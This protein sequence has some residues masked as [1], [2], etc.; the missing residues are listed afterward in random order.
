MKTIR[1]ILFIL[2]CLSL[3]SGIMYYKLRKERAAFENEINNL[4]TK[5]TL[6]L[7]KYSEEKARARGLLRTKASL[8]GKQRA[9]LGKITDLEKENTL[10]TEERNTLQQKL[11]KTT[12]SL[13][14]KLEDLSKKYSE[15]KAEI[16]EMKQTHAQTVKE[17]EEK[18]RVLTSEKRALNGELKIKQQKLERYYLH[19]TKL[20]GINNE[21]LEMYK[22]KGVLG[23]LSHNEPFTG[24]KKVEL[25]HLI[26]EYKDKVESH[27]LDETGS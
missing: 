27:T 14:A 9:L 11:K 17:F 4:K 13:E 21:L 1:V 6:A 12:G 20:V 10:L 22:N 16:T 15:A 8:E 23:S 24:I 5:M 7:K 18:T 26:Q 3:G 2:I 19:N 25:E